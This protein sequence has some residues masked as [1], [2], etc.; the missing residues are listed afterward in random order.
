[1]PN[2][3]IIIKKSA[4][5]KKADKVFKDR[6]ESQRSRYYKV[7]VKASDPQARAGG[8]SKIKMKE[9]TQ[10]KA[11]KLQA[12]TPRK[13]VENPGKLAQNVTKATGL[14]GV[15]RYK[16]SKI[17]SGKSNLNLKGKALSIVAGKKKVGE[18]EG[19]K[20]G[21]QYEKGTKG[22]QSYVGTKEREQLKSI[23]FKSIPPK[24]PVKRVIPKMEVKASADSDVSIRKEETAA[25]K[26]LTVKAVGKKP[27]ATAAK[28]TSSKSGSKKYFIKHA[29]GSQE[30]V[31]EETRKKFPH[32]FK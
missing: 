29:D 6:P 11:E 12:K 20:P 9:I 18:M 32:R 30:Q 26:K 25:K 22:N 4:G 28:S 1:M 31:S 17:A 7:K 15:E 27:G 3:K 14:T 13:N 10:K 24:P 16:G 21:Y 8:Y 23:P 19:K 5:A 2:P